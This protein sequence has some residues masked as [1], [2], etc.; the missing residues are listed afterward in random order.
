[1]DGSC[2]AAEFTVVLAILGDSK[3]ASAACNTYNAS[4]MGGATG[5]ALAYTAQQVMPLFKSPTGSC[6]ASAGASV[7]SDASAPQPYVADWLSP[8]TA[9]ACAKPA[10]LDK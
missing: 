9:P 1:M 10:Q 7:Q 3:S 2:T 5:A 4:Q 6:A 8:Y